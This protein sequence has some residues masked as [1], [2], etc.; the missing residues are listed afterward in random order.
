MSGV[1]IIIKGVDYSGLGLGKVS[2]IQINSVSIIGDDI[3]N[4]SFK[5]NAVV[6]TG[7]DSIS[8]LW[9]IVNGSEFAHFENDGNLIVNDGV[10][11]KSVTIK[12]CVKGNENI[13]DTKEITVNSILINT[14]TIDQSYKNADHVIFGGDI[15]GEVVNSIKDNT[16]RYLSKHTGNGEMSIIQLNDENTSYYNQ[17]GMADIENNDVF[18]KLPIFYY[19][20][21]EIETDVFEISLSENLI[22]ESWKKFD[23]DKRL[24]GA[25]FT[26]KTDSRSNQSITSTTSMYNRTTINQAFKNKGTGY[27][28]MTLTWVNILKLLMIAKYGTIRPEECF[29]AAL[30]YFSG[31]RT[32]DTNGIGMEDT[33]STSTVSQNFFG[34]EG[35]TMPTF[36][37]DVSNVSASGNIYKVD[38]ADGT[39]YQF[40]YPLAQTLDDKA[41][42]ITK[43]HLGENINF[44]PKA[45]N[46]SVTDYTKYWKTATSIYKQGGTYANTEWCY[47]A[48]YYTSTDRGSNN[49]ILMVTPNLRNTSNSSVGS[50]LTFYGNVNIINN[51]EEFE[52]LTEI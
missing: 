44:T 38:D 5:F 31:K 21:T 51:V 50:R 35:L 17:G 25:Y 18:V 52:Q 10:F 37:T 16:H 47:R 9:S 49:G 34:V 14:I 33:P 8:F 43:L 11:D 39:T 46:E 32:G 7:T 42:I 12:V 48:F 26:I 22:D 27:D 13:F 20:S 36:V 23:G 41:V 6:D 30:N 29:G 40:A 19:K 3:V 4:K 15:N 2:P 24:I 1:A 28:G 45:I